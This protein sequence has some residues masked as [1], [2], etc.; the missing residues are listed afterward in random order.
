MNSSRIMERNLSVIKLNALTF[1]ESESVWL[2]LKTPARHVDDKQA[3][4]VF[5]R[6]SLN[7]TENETPLC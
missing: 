5:P 7:I 3:Q 2:H 4:S 6:A 1:I